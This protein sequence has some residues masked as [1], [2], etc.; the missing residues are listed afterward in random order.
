LRVKITIHS[1]IRYAERIENAISKEQS[2][3]LSNKLS[4][5]R[6]KAKDVINIISKKTKLSHSK[7]VDKITSEV[8]RS[9]LKNFAYRKSDEEIRLLEGVIYVCKYK[10]EEDTMVLLTVYDRR[11]FKPNY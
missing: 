11:K 5:K 1:L 7:L 8:R 10:Y 6:I 4:T 2:D 9:K 3:I